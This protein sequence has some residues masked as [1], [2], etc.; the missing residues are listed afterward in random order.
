M[1][2]Y[3]EYQYRRM[4]PGTS[5]EDYLDLP[6]DEVAWMLAIDGAVATAERNQRQKGTS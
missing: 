2:W 3:Q 4:L 1:A 5:H 6:V